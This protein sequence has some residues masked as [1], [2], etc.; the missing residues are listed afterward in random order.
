M[1]RILFSGGF[2]L[3]NL[4]SSL[5]ASLI[6]IFII[7]PMHEMAHGAAAI[8]LG[9]K[10]PKYQGR[11]TLNPMAHIDW[12]GALMIILFGFGWAKP[13][14]VNMYNFKNPKRDMALC[15]AAG[16]LS[17]FL[18]SFIIGIFLWPALSFALK[19]SVIGGIIYYIME[20]LVIYSIYIGL[21]NLIP[22][23]PFDGSRILTAFL[24]N[25]YYYMLMRL[26]RYSFIIVI[27][28]FNLLD[29]GAGLSNVAG[30]LLYW[31]EQISYL[32]FG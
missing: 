28:L 9:D 27:V 31:F 12:L 30:F 6:L 16:P 18:F 7:S 13:V 15:A 24:P 20:Y 10:T 23:P 5:M 8:A 21:F 26:E 32:I 3:Y 29:F 4:L 19:G 22:I 11:M 17:N 14:Q 2:S 25:R 1:L